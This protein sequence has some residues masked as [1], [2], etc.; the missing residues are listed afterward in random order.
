MLAFGRTL[1][2]CRA[3]DIA[4]GSLAEVGDPLS[5]ADS[6]IAE[7]MSSADKVD[8]YAQEARRLEI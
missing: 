8:E 3:I 2:A 6:I 7:I 1:A 4:I 5:E